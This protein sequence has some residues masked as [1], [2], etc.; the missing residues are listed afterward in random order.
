MWSHYTT[1]KGFVIELDKS[2]L[3]KT[4]ENDHKFKHWFFPANYVN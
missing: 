4:L 3:I 1:D 2:K